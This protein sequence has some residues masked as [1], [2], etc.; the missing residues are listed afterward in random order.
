MQTKLFE[1]LKKYGALLITLAVIAAF[2]FYF[3]KN[4]EEFKVL[5]SVGKLEIFL[6]FMLQGVGLIFSA[7]FY[8]DLF[9]PLNENVKFKD[10]LLSAAITSVGN[11]FLPL[12]GGIGLRAV[13]FKKYFDISY[14]KFLSTLSG[15]FVIT[16]STS[17]LMSLISL[18]IIYNKTGEFSLLLFLFFLGI[19]LSMIAFIFIKPLK[20]R[21]VFLQFIIDKVNLIIEGW[22]AVRKF[23]NTLFKLFFSFFLQVLVSMSITY[24]E[25]KIVGIELTIEKILLYLGIS[26]LTILINLTPGGLG[27]REALIIFFAGALSLTNEQILHVAVIDR[28]ILFFFLLVLFLVLRIFSPK[29]FKLKS[30]EESK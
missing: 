8:R 30:S 15:I 19:F 18:L 29:L 16:F 13:Y 14:T 4:I 26:S 9:Q 20:I 11:Y 27:V 6:I 3:I 22:N 12:Q 28:G 5:L 21:V 10:G 17:A 7:I 24:L 23:G 25:F 2:V 1:K